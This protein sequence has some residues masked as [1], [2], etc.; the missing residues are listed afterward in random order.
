MN[1]DFSKRKTL[2]ELKELVR[3]L[4]KRFNINYGNLIDMAKV[5][6]ALDS[7]ILVEVDEVTRKIVAVDR[8]KKVPSDAADRIRFGAKGLFENDL[9]NP[10]N[11]RIYIK[12]DVS[13]DVLFHKILHFITSEHL[14]IQDALSRAYDEDIKLKVLSGKTKEEIKKYGRQVEQ[15]D[16]SMTRFITELA[17]PEA[18]IKDAYRYGAKIIRNYY[19]LVS[20][21][22]KDTD[23]IFNMYLNGEPDI[24]DTESLEK[25]KQS[26]GNK[27]YDVLDSIEQVNNMKLYLPKLIHPMSPEAI[28]ET[29]RNAAYNVRSK[30]R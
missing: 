27:F 24:G 21:S 8:T 14:G 22:G 28:A 3:L 25:F 20:N 12:S 4:Y 26:F 5:E 7:I 23:F 9:N 2:E 11:N 15:F 18:N 10:A 6:K 16:E 19:E 17:I 1:I 30:R 29:I 13:V